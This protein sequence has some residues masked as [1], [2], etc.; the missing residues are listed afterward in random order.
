MEE[1]LEA[2]KKFYE[3]CED[4][5]D[6][7]VSVSR[8]GTVVVRGDVFRLGPFAKTQLCSRAG[9]SEK[10]FDVLS[11]RNLAD[12]L[13]A[14]LEDRKWLVR[15]RSRRIRALLTNRYNVIDHKDV[16]EKVLPAL[17]L[18]KVFFNTQDPSWDVLLDH[19]AVIRVE[20]ERRKEEK[21]KAVYTPYL[22]IRNSEVGTGSV[23]IGLQL[24]FSRGL[25]LKQLMK[26]SHLSALKA[27]EGLEDAVMYLFDLAP[28][29]QK[30]CEVKVKI[31]P[32]DRRFFVFRYGRE[33]AD[34]LW[35][36]SKTDVS[37]RT[38]GELLE[39]TTLQ[40]IPVEMRLRLQM[41]LFEVLVRAEDFVK[42]GWLVGWPGTGRAR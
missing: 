27:L 21:T 23:M 39:V 32:I 14:V 5:P 6:E 36:G 42:E 30:S 38:L 19:I 41:D 35:P 13:N 1:F 31:R 11:E 26:I 2:L 40:R 29:I 17:K 7:E 34:A 8:D 15:T 22:M 12:V 25:V 28:L 16:V 10:F 3:G 20:G 9:C 33:L 4:F 37:E 18:S 24:A